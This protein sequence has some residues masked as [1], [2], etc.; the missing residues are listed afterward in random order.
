MSKLQED[1]RSLELQLVSEKASRDQEA[2]N[3]AMEIEKNNVQQNAQM[4]SIKCEAESWKRKA[5]ATNAEC[6]LL[7]E[8]M[9]AVEVLFNRLLH[10]GVFIN[11]VSTY[12]C[13]LIDCVKL[14]NNCVVD[15]EKPS[16][17]QVGRAKVK[18][19]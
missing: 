2:K 11:V 18:C 6:T 1:K 10:S 7:K 8:Q 16:N 9:R 19:K 15:G 14:Y 13:I 4:Y 5:D 3:A 12:V 17:A